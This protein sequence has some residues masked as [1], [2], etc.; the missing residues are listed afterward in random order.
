MHATGLV[1]AMDEQKVRLHHRYAH[2]SL[3]E[4][5]VVN[6]WCS[7]DWSRNEVIIDVRM[8]DLTFSSS[9]IRCPNNTLIMVLHWLMCVGWMYGP[10]RLFPH[11]MSKHTL[12]WQLIATLRAL[13]FVRSCVARLE[14]FVVDVWMIEV[15][16][17]PS[18]S[19]MCCPNNALQWR[20]HSFNVWNGCHVGRGRTARTFVVI[21]ACAIDLT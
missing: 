5:E 18:S 4:L 15:A 8:I 14:R 9:Y 10:T 20:C 12:Q 1:S 11:V 3:N 21:A 7:N 17:S 2:M 16:M 19:H 13:I 6:Y